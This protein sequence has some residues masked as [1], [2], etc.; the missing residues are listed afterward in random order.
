M[1]DMTCHLPEPGCYG[2][3]RFVMGGEMKIVCAP[4]AR[5]H[6]HLL[7]KDGQHYI[8]NDKPTILELLRW[9]RSC[10]KEDVNS[11][12]RAGVPVFYRRNSAIIMPPGFLLS[13]R[14]LNDRQVHGV[15]KSFLCNSTGAAASLMVLQQLHANTPS[16]AAEAA[17]LLKVTWMTT[18]SRG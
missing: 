17:A 4:A 7:S 11:A 1:P 14:P 15:R 5:L 18:R 16:L 13:V 8:D 6:A 3:V 2:T 9:V 12:V 10:G